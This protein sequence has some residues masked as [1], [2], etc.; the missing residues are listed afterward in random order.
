MELRRGGGRI[1]GMAARAAGMVFGRGS[2]S[3][4]TGPGDRRQK[5]GAEH[6]GEQR[7]ET[8]EA[9]AQGIVGEELR[10]LGWSE[11][12]LQ[13][14]RKGDVRELRMAARLQRETTMT[15]EWIAGRLRMGTRTH[16][17]RLLYWRQH[18]QRA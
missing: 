16:L 9:K 8:A 17:S 7:H 11:K 18:G 1:R 12:R 4:G 5:V 2:L 13:A 3:Q 14:E 10:R 6:Y 15:L